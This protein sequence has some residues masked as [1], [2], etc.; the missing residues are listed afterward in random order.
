MY[1]NS[2]NTNHIHIKIVNEN[3]TIV[4]SIKNNIQNDNI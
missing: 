4:V 1:N 2:K 3:N